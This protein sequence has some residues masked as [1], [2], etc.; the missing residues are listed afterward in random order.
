MV[1]LAELVMAF[2]LEHGLAELITYMQLAST[3]HEVTVDEEV[4]EHIHWRLEDGSRRSARLARIIFA[5][6]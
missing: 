4:M 1:S 6:T 5:R 2:P 3:S